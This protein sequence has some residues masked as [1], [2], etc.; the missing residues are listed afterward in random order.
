MEGTRL[1]R[2]LQQRDEGRPYDSK[3]WVLQDSNL[4]PAGYEP[5]ALTI[6]LRTRK[7]RESARPGAFER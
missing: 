3:W 7:H 6:E 4:Q 5:D 1:R 2:G